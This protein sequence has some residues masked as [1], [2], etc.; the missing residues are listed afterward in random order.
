MLPGY[1]SLKD[2]VLGRH[3]E[4]LVFN[5]ISTMFSATYPLHFLTP[6]HLR[7]TMQGRHKI[8]TALRSIPFEVS[9]PGI[10]IVTSPDNDRWRWR[11]ALKTVLEEGF[12]DIQHLF[13]FVNAARG[14]VR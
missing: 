13:G 10:S 2:E 7:E 11:S 12:Q 5:P 14:H 6:R 9:L 8:Q 1:R 3:K 4:F